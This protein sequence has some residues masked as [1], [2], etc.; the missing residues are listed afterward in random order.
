MNID[1]QFALLNVYIKWY[2]VRNSFG[3]LL[4]IGMHLDEMIKLFLVIV[5]MQMEICQRVILKCSLGTMNRFKFN[6]I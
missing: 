1:S 6:C 3:R 5:K 2:L 4:E